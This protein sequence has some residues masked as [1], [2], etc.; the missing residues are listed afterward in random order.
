MEQT[1]AGKR[2]SCQ[3]R[4]SPVQYGSSDD[5]SPSQS[6]EGACFP[7]QPVSPRGRISRYSAHPQRRI[8]TQ[9]DHVEELREWMGGL[10]DP[11]QSCGLTSASIHN[12]PSAGI[13]ARKTGWMVGVDEVLQVNLWQQ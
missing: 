5:V 1:S 6:H 7:S 11:A 10:L 9:A 2:K 4:D 8:K 13:P 3:P 12:C